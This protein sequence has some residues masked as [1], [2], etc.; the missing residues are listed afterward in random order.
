MLLNP[1]LSFSPRSNNCDLPGAFGGMGLPNAAET[2]LQVVGHDRDQNHVGIDFGRI[3]NHIGQPDDVKS[4][5]DSLADIAVI[6]N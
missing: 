1:G 4:F 2:K 3:N 6:G 5:N